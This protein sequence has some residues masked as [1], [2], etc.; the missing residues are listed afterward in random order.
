MIRRPPIPALQPFVKESWAADSTGSSAESRP[1]D[2]EHVLP[3][4]S[5]HLVFRL[6]S[7]PLKVYRQTGEAG[8]ISYGPVVIGGVRSVYYIRDI[9]RPTRS[10]GVLLKPG[11]SE[12]LF[13]SHSDEFSHRHTCVDL[14]WGREAELI[15][16]Q[17]SELSQVRQLAMVES[18]L[19]RRLSV[20]DAPSQVMVDALKRLEARETIR[21]VVEYSGYS[22][23][24][25]NALFRR[26]VG[27]TPKA[28]SRILQFQRLVD[29]LKYSPQQSMAEIALE[30]GY[31]DQAHCSRHFL[32]TAGI[33][34]S[35]YRRLAPQF[36]RH[37]KLP[38]T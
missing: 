32:A 37:V 33:T 9:S 21:S 10:V 6:T 34:L 36:H 35:E 14:V 16:E 19:A 24:H 29:R 13:G 18:W 38:S 23:R 1:G 4:G 26:F 11:V 31:S 8:G 30:A 17:L 20:A 28:Y 12:W 2:R 22:H 27:L 15:R 5:M 3:T 7:D 25:F